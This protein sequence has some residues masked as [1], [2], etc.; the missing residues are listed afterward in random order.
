LK[1][2]FVSG[3]YLR[4]LVAGGGVGEYVVQVRGENERGVIS[5]GA[6][7]SGAGIGKRWMLWR[8]RERRRNGDGTYVGR[9]L[10]VFG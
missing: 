10:C 2:F 6:G 8:R 3:I 4:L 5:P 7:E 1:V 9:T